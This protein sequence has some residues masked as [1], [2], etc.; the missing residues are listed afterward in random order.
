M[1]II[2]F[3]WIFHLK[4]S[5]WKNPAI[6]LGTSREH[7]ENIRR[8]SI[9]NLE[10]IQKH[11]WS[12]E[13]ICEHL[14]TSEHILNTSEN[15]YRIF[16][17]NWG[18][19]ENIWKQLRSS[20]NIFGTFENIFGT[21]ENIFGTSEN[22]WHH[23]EKKCLHRGWLCI[24]KGV[25]MHKS[26]NPAE[27]MENGE[28]KVLIAKCYTLSHTVHGCFSWN[29]RFTRIVWPLFWHFTISCFHPFLCFDAVVADFIPSIGAWAN[30]LGSETTN[31]VEPKL[32][33]TIITVFT[34]NLLTALPL[35]TEPNKIHE[36]SMHIML[37][38]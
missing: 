8:T 19:P 3:L 37:D 26:C 23:L 36:Y 32:W 34:A 18:H 14:R 10:K 17:I 28:I 2:E 5:S 22:I 35:C 7:L 9:E 31:Y 33:M 1:G 38:L 30:C 25:V 27:N 12:S 4:W 15:L 20:E 21:F 13:N 6:I 16:V 24:A 29:T 11:L